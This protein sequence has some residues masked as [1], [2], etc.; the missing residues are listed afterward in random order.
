MAAKAV[1]KSPLLR[2]AANHFKDASLAKDILFKFQRL[3]WD[4]SVAL[5]EFM[6]LL[7]IFGNEELEMFSC[8]VGFGGIHEICSL[9]NKDI[10]ESAVR[11]ETKSFRI[12]PLTYATKYDLT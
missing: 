8:S 5:N 2:I 6:K 1:A 12:L 10:C 4:F 7:A 9:L 3:Y 11:L